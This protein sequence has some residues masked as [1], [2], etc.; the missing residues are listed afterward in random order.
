MMAILEEHDLKE[1]VTLIE[2]IE[3]LKLRDRGYRW[4]DVIPSDDV[5]VVVWNELYEAYIDDEEEVN[6]WRATAQDNRRPEH[7]RGGSGDYRVADGN[8]GGFVTGADLFTD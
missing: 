8:G 4:E 3:A 1:V 7:Y 6:A 2:F 5:D